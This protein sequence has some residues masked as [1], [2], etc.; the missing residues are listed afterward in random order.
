MTTTTMATDV[1]DNDDEG[2][3]ASLTG[4]D[5][6]D[7]RNRNISK[8]AC[9][10]V[11]AM[12]QPIVRRRRVDAGNTPERGGGDPPSDVNTLERRGGDPQS[13]GNTL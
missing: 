2:N 12:T 3:D 5:K 9:A 10:L 11:K 7:N 8:D 4:C 6:G 1:D 13:D